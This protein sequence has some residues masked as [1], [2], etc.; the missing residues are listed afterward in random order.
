VIRLRDISKTYIVDEEDIRFFEALKSINLTLAKKELVVILGKSGSGKSTLLN[1][2]S[3]LDTF[4]NGTYYYF[5]N[6]VNKFEQM[7]FDH[8]RSEKM[9]MVFQNYHLVESMTVL[10][11]VVLAQR[12]GMMKRPD[13]QTAKEA[14]KEVGMDGLEDRVVYRLSS[15][16]R[17]RV[18]IARGIVNNPVML[19]ADEPTGNLDSSTAKDILDL[20]KKL[21][22]DRLV[23]MVT[24]DEEA[25]VDYADKVVQIDD[26]TV[27]LDYRVTDSGKELVD[28]DVVFKKKRNFRGSLWMGL[29]NFTVYRRRI[30]AMVALLA[31][32][33]SLICASLFYQK[34]YESLLSGL[35]EELSNRN[36]FLLEMDQEAFAGKTTEEVLTMVSTIPG[37]EVYDSPILALPVLAFEGAATA[38]WNTVEDVMFYPRGGLPLHESFYGNGRAPMTEGEIV[39]SI[40]QAKKLVRSDSFE[41]IWK[42]LDQAEFTVPLEVKRQVDRSSF[43]QELTAQNPSCVLYSLD[44]EGNTGDFREDLFGEYEG[45]VLLLDDLFGLEK[46]PYAGNQH[47]SCAESFLVENSFYDMEASREERKITSTMV[48]KVVGIFSN[49]YQR[50][51]YLHADTYEAMRGKNHVSSKQTLIAYSPNSEPLDA[52]GITYQRIDQEN[53]RLTVLRNDSK[54]NQEVIILVFISCF[55]ALSSIMGF[56]SILGVQMRKERKTIAVIRSVGGS[57]LDVGMIFSV[58]GILTGL[59]VVVFVHVVGFLML[60]LGNVWIGTFPPDHILFLFGKAPSSMFEYSYEVTALFSLVGF[61]GSHLSFVIAGKNTSKEKILALVRDK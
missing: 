42:I 36:V 9:G 57:S 12:F 17:Q 27:V 48:L 10:E 44:E 32:S 31:F 53:G 37:M 33:L 16:E 26:G 29:R 19:L 56:F 24:H 45:Y 54:G 46:I 55:L 14:L 5:D 49:P 4:D 58:Q 2:I 47:F 50:H 40:D 8:F 1:I 30:L 28:E 13:E 52:L 3:G 23:V 61:L 39:L 51:G 35:S 38:V 20:L 7:H 43:I 34:G 22:K 11:N 6:R 21:S 60:L 41:E 25:A 18:A 59:S 15:G